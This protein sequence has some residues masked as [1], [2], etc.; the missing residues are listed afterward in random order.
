[1][2]IRQWKKLVLQDIQ[3]RCMI[4]LGKD[5]RSATTEE[6]RVTLNRVEGVVGAIWRSV[7]N[8]HSTL[9]SLGEDN[10]TFRVSGAYKTIWAS[11]W[12]A[13]DFLTKDV[14]DLLVLHEIEPKQMGSRSAV[15]YS[16]MFFDLCGEHVFAC[17]DYSET[18]HVG[19]LCNIPK[20]EWGT[21]LN[22]NMADE[23]I[24]EKQKLEPL[25][26][27]CSEIL[28]SMRALE[29]PA[30]AIS[31]FCDEFNTWIDRV[32]QAS[33]EVRDDDKGIPIE[34]AVPALTEAVNSFE[35]L[36]SAES[37]RRTAQ[38]S[39]HFERIDREL[40]TLRESKVQFGQQAFNGRESAGTLRGLHGEFRK[41]IELFRRWSTLHD[42]ALR[43]DQFSQSET[44]VTNSNQ[45]QDEDCLISESD[46]D[47]DLYRSNGQ[48]CD[49]K[50]AQDRFGIEPQTLSKGRRQKGVHG[51]Q[52]L[53]KKVQPP[54]GRSFYVHRRQ[55]LE[56]LSNAIDPENQTGE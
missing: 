39:P 28:A 20:S 19:P 48:W 50:F 18:K 12:L 25:R 43:D 8:L 41:L 5:R 49:A 29:L 44:V 30:D 7:A 45:N 51:V 13:N 56:A 32:Y 3:N 17:S 53:W 26:E 52:V 11:Y 15:T 1:M 31:R 23:S 42:N 55:D 16:I 14:R 24:F 36:N 6:D 35:F 34:D 21:W 4:E 40:Q 46:Q 47:A 27:K 38:N 9:D 37:V 33:I 10:D 54:K 22:F 2:A